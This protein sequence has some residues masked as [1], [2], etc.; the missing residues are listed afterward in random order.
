MKEY[1]ETWKEHRRMM[2]RTMGSK[3]VV[4]EGF[5]GTQVGEV[6]RLLK[7]LAKNGGVGFEENLQRYVSRPRSWCSLTE[8]PMWNIG[9]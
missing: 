8:M 4:E 5:E 2:G 3:R 1:G 9:Q 6:R 7:R